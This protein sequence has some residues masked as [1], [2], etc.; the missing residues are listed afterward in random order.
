MEKWIENSK[1]HGFSESIPR[2]VALDILSKLSYKSL[3]RFK[4]VCKGWRCLISSPQFLKENFLLANA[5]NDSGR[6]WRC[7]YVVN[8]GSTLGSGPFVLETSE[9]NGSTREVRV[10]HGPTSTREFDFLGS[11]NG[12][13]LLSRGRPGDDLFIW[14][15]CSG[16]KKKVSCPDC[17]VLGLYKI[18]IS[19][20]A[21][22]S[23]SED[24][25]AVFGAWSINYGYR[26][27]LLYA[28]RTNT[29]KVIYRKGLP[30]MCDHSSEQGAT[31]NGAPHWLFGRRDILKLIDDRSIAYFDPAEEKFRKLS[32][33]ADREAIFDTI[34]LGALGGCLSVTY[35]DSLV[36]GGRNM[37]ETWVMREYGIEE[38]W[39]KL[40]VFFPNS[41]FDYLY[42]RPLCFTTKD[43]VLMELDRKRLVVY[44]IR[45]GS[46]T[47]YVSS[48]VQNKL[49]YWGASNLG[50]ELAT[51]LETSDFP[52]MGTK[53]RSFSGEYKVR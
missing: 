44:N 36:V 10:D 13:L 1:G 34:A 18:S 23:S 19:G 3:Q 53:K 52:A 40:F 41:I 22:D 16:K 5:R 47:Q 7:M 39:M 27:I 6:L 51:Y 12:L 32:L 29:W 48:F 33:P 43:E 20:L 31:V 24:Y 15:P 2:D 46:V 38:S 8:R 30:F 21:Y 14:N 42:L 28:F 26:G 45:D 17:F 37:S 49:I 25:K 35:Y 50:F 9:C 11:C 4:S